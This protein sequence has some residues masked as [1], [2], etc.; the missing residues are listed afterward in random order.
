MT[1]AARVEVT[2]ADRMTPIFQLCFACIGERT[3]PDG[4]ACQ[5]CAGTG[6]DPN[7]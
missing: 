4:T 3:G 5:R 1:A 7:F 2:D 6:L